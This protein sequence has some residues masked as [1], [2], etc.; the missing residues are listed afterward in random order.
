MLVLGPI[1]FAVPWAL[2]GLLVLPALWWL[3]RIT[4]PPPQ[5]VKFPA[6]RLL[7]DLVPPEETPSKTPLWIILLRMAIIAAIVLGLAGPILHPGAAG[8]RGGTLLVAV[9]DGWA[10]APGWAVRQT[11]L[12]GLL[13]KA[14]REQRLVAVLPTAR[15]ADGT[16][17]ALIGPNRPEKIRGAVE[18]LRPMPWG[19]SREAAVVALA[20]ADLGKNTEA[21]WLSDGV[22]SMGADTLATVVAAFSDAR[23]VTPSPGALPQMLLPPTL[24]GGK[25]TL[26]VLRAASG[27]AQSVTVSAMTLDGQT[28]S[29]AEAKFAAT[30][31]AASALLDLPVEVANRIDRLEIAG[32]HSAGAT[33]LLD[34]RYRRRPVGLLAGTVTG[35]TLLRGNTYLT[36]A[37]E[38]YADITR[39]S[40]D[41]LLKHPLSTILLDD[42][43]PL[44]DQDQA[45]LRDWADK[46]GIIVRFAGPQLAEKSDALLPVTLRA[47]DRALGG[48]LSWTV[49]AKLQPFPADS[50]F[51]GLPLSPDVTV[52]RQVLAQPGIDAASHVWAALADGTPLVT[53]EAIG[54]GWLV[55]VHTTASPAW[56]NLCLS[57]TFV[58][59]LRRLNELGSGLNAS[60]ARG[61]SLA[62]IS[63]LDGFGSLGDAAPTAVA[64]DANAFDTTQAEPLHPPGYYGNH[65]LRRAFNLPRPNSTLTRLPD[66]PRLAAATYTE[67]VER[68]LKPALLTLALL[69]LAIDALAALWL[70][71]LLRPR[72]TRALAVAALV[73]ITSQAHAQA[74]DTLVH[75]ATSTML[76]YVR[77]GDAHID[78]LSAAGLQ[79]LSQTLIARTSV[80]DMAS[81]PV[82][83]EHDPL[84]FY[85]LIYWPISAIMPTPSQSAI[86]KLNTYLANGGMLVIDTRDADPD[87]TISATLKRLTAG[88]AI[89]ALQPVPV[90]HALTKSFYLLD[91]FPGRT[92]DPKVWVEQSP[93][94]QTDNVSS[95]VVGN[96]DWASA[97]AMD[98][99]GNA[100]VDLGGGAEQQ[101]LALRFGVNLVL[102]ALTGN[103]KTDQIHTPAILERLGQ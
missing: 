26:R 47:G 65:T 54:S 55:L 41:D 73:L 34:T 49:P 94:D 69:L 99:A 68:S 15:N 62:P 89:P 98:A 43:P 30:D 3:L 25:L 32:Q 82:D 10:A 7:R 13:D 52:S 48:S 14:E 103:Y 51:A 79:S 57:G 35:S 64:L 63:T 78:T 17:P 5:V 28:L 61:G 91:R 76:G 58:E 44:A 46:G 31:E 86:A 60:D 9:D 19:V 84:A 81:G 23:V 1:G 92:I 71:G 16:A 93:S 97:W 66:F 8:T 6:I 21:H 75:D 2:A 27:Y 77:T 40:L 100:V 56:S 42:P 70:K 11:T 83:L 85:P 96:G 102:Y 95:I 53:A 72:M 37:L 38:P 36:A 20:R 18:A 101:E 88:L 80:N 12:T 67:A 29:T 33:V 50:P 4:P 59:M 22:T 39:G 74:P 24:A 87:L 90:G 45:K